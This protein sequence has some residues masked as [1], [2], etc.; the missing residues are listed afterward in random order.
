MRASIEA[1]IQANKDIREWLRSQG[2]CF[3]NVSLKQLKMFNLN[4]QDNEVQSL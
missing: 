3:I 4:N 1:A 2:K